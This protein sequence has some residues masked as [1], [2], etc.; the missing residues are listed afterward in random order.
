MNPCGIARPD[1]RGIALVMALIVLTVISLLAMVLMMTVTTESKLAGHNRGESSALNIAE[2]GI[3]EATSRIGSGEIDFGV[4]PRG[5]AVIFNANAGSVP[6]VGVDT[7]ALATAQPA[8]TWLGYSTATKT[9][10]VLT[11]SYKTNAARTLIYKYDP[12][13]PQPV[14]TVSGYPIYVITSTGR[15]GTDV[16]KVVT[17][18]SQKPVLVNVFGAVAARNNVGWSGND[19][20]CGYNHRSDTPTGAGSSGR[21]G[22]G[23]PCYV[24][25]SQ[26]ETGAGPLVGMWSS[27]TITGAGTSASGIPPT[28]ASQ[29]TFY[30]GPWEALGMSQS[31]FWSWVGAPRTTAPPVPTG[32]IYLDND[33]TT[34]N[35]LGNFAFNG[36][37]GEGFLYVD[38]NLTLN[39]N[40][41]YRGLIYVEGNL[42]INSWTWVLGGVIIRGQTGNPVNWHSNGTILYSKDAITQKIAKYSG[43]FVTLSWREI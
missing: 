27:G 23:S 3:A 1:Q 42:S 35:Q 6:G 16:R 17:E 31:A 40:F 38:G 2:A 41:H 20:M 29:P 43:Q 32:I 21:L 33:A 15:A 12:S 14:Q 22:G 25:P 9:A 36:G 37:D 8:G 13:L 26:W 5:T 30:A 18:I 4:N 10:D 19:Y 11:V 28:L 39:G 34:Q 7:T 24:N